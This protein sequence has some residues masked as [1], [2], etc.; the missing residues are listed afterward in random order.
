MKTLVVGASVNPSRYSHLAI[1]QLLQK[2][3]EVIAIG[4]HEGEV[5]DVPIMTEWPL[6]IPNLHTVTIYIR[7]ALQDEII[8]HIIRYHP[9]RV[10]FNPGTE[11]PSVMQRLEAEG[12]HVVA[13]CTLVMLSIGDFDS[14]D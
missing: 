10:I 2:G 12:I 3:H 6:E 8:E 11:N 1:I 14:I 4:N 13:A 7:P 5:W 9:Q